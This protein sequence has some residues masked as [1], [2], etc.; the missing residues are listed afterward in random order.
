MNKQDLESRIYTEY[1]DQFRIFVI[2]A[3]IFLF[4]EFIIMDRKNR[5]LANIKLFRYKI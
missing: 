1:N 2:A 3:L 4:A 5:K